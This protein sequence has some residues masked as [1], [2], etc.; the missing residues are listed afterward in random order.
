M[1]F[2]LYLGPYQPFL[3]DELLRSFQAFREKVPFDPV[4][5]LVPNALLA[6]HLRKVLAERDGRVF[7]L[8]V[9]TLRHYLEDLLEERMVKEDLKSL[10]DTLTPWVLKE[11][12]RQVKTSAFAAVMETPGFFHSLKAT[13]SELREGL[14]TPEKLTAAGSAKFKEFAVLLKAYEAWKKRG[15]WMDREDYYRMSLETKGTGPVWVY[16][17]YDASALQKKALV[18]LSGEGSSW[19]I[20]YEEHPAFEYAKPFVEWAKGNGTVEKVGKYESGKGT[21]LGRLQDRMF[22]EGRKAAAEPG[23]T[24]ESSDCKILLCPGEP[25]EAVEIGR[26]LL[27]EADRTG[28]ELSSC[29]VVLRDTHSYRKILPPVLAAQGIPLGRTIASPLV[30]T[31]DSKALLLLLDCF[32]RD[33]PRDTVMDFLSCPNLDPQGFG[34]ALEEWDPS[35]WDLLSREAKVVE[36]K[37]EW[38]ARLSA[39]RDSKLRGNKEQEEA[40]DVKE[41]LRSA[42]AFQK[43][44]AVLFELE[45]RFSIPRSWEQRATRLKDAFL[46]CT[47]ESPFRGEVTGSL[48][49]LQL[50]VKSFATSLTGSLFVD[51]PLEDF[52]SVLA[53]LLEEKKTK[54]PGEEGGARVVDL[55]E[56]RGV[57]FD[58]VALPGLV[59]RSVP[60]L[61]RQDPLLLD[62]ERTLLNEKGGEAFIPLKRTGAL[63]ERLLFMLAVRSARKSLLLTAPLMN[64]STGSPRTPSIY[65][66]ASAEAVLGRRLSRLGEAPGLVKSIPLSDWKKPSIADCADPLELLL[67]AFDQARKGDPS[68]ALALVKD[69]DFYFEGRDL[70]KARQASRLFTAYD[71]ILSAAA[72]EGL[73]GHSLKGLSLSAS[74]LET[75]A[76]CP[77][78]YFYKYILRLTVPPDPERVIQIEASD[79]GNLMHEVLEKTLARGLKEGWTGTRDEEAG[80]KALEEETKKAFDHFE[81]HG[82]TGAPALWVWEKGQMRRD[83]EK[84]LARVIQDKDWTPLDFEVGFGGEKEVVFP[85]EDGTVLRLQGRM[86]RVDASSDGKDLRVVDYKTGSS[87]GV[88]NNGVKAGVK[89]QLPFYLWALKSLYPEKNPREALYDFITRKGGY[90][91]SSYEGLEEEKVKAPLAQVLAT[92]ASSVERGIFP[93]AAKD[94]PF[95]DYRPLCGTGMEARGKKKRDD[96]KTKDYF[97]LEGLE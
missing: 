29:A 74:R 77:L 1:S 93:A 97:G 19:F 34:L 94:C 80:R 96:E 36:G 47:L 83:L 68:T 40:Q 59:E 48:D 76:A 92:A 81:K 18:H 89:L 16:G 79:R 31:L 26:S 49:N 5:V 28:S 72:L 25:R 73:K 57:S 15:G 20:P 41:D 71:G 30:E 87:T 91:R 50:L 9:H 55:M 95:C 35:R 51:G 23:G 7:N 2:S 53:A 52:R 27:R 85:L 66:F 63:E 4:T 37:K 3:E 60:K 84:V 56:A 78:R 14:F 65:L 44:L 43:V 42:E 17:F 39:W 13:L 33:F 32:I 70:L 12:S 69:K 38:P 82:V 11:V 21:P 88:K 24:F 58:V 54:A 64:P 62:D 46:K 8:R 45:R 86:D 61:V 75:F 22:L 67:T 6:G 90:K 10:P